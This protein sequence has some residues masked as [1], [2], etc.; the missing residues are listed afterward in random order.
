MTESSDNTLDRL[1]EILK[2]IS[3]D[4][5]LQFLNIDPEDITPDEIRFDRSGRLR[6]WSRL[7]KVVCS[8]D[9]LRSHQH[10]LAFV[11]LLGHFSAG[12]STMINAIVG[13]PGQREAYPNPT[14][15]TITLICH[16]RNIADLR[17]NPFTSI[18]GVTIE[19]G[20]SIELLEN[21]V[22]VDTPGL[23]NLAAEHDMAERFLHLCHVIVVTIDGQVP[24]ADTAGNLSLLDKIINK[25]GDVPKIF[26]VTKSVQF[27]SDRKG[28]FATHWN[29][30][31]ADNF[32]AGVTS[33]LTSDARFSRAGTSIDDIPVIFVDSIDGYNIG[34]LIEKFVPIT[35]DAS[36]RPRTYDAQ[37][38]Y[39]VQIALEAIK[40]FNAYLQDRLA[41][42][43]SL[44]SQ[45][46]TKADEARNM[47][48]RRQDAVLSAIVTATTKIDT[49]QQADDITQ[50]LLPVPEPT[51]VL[52]RDRFGE[53][54]AAINGIENHLRDV[55]RETTNSLR[56]ESERSTGGQFRLFF[57]SKKEY[58][59]EE[60]C[61]NAMDV[62]S[63][64]RSYD[65]HNLLIA[66]ASY[67]EKAHDDIVWDI[68][69]RWSNRSLERSAK[70][71]TTAFTEAFQALAGGLGTFISSYNVAAR[72]FVAY[73]TQP[74]SKKLMAEYGVVL[75]DDDDESL[76]LEAAELANSDFAAFGTADKV[77]KDVRT[78]LARIVDD[79]VRELA[80]SNIGDISQRL[81][82]PSFEHTD[83]HQFYDNHDKRFRH[84]ANQ[85]LSE[86]QANIEASKTQMAEA[87]A[88]CKDT[89]KDIWLGWFEFTVKM[90]V[91]WVVLYATI[92]IVKRS[93]FQLY[94]W[95]ADF[96][97]TSWEVLLLSMVGA[98]IVELL[99]FGARRN[100]DFVSPSTFS[101]GLRAIYDFAKGKKRIKTAFD[102]YLDS[103]SGRLRQRLKEKSLE[104][105]AQT[106][107]ILGSKIDAAVSEAGV[108]DLKDVLQKYRD[109]R[110]STYQRSRQLFMNSTN[111]LRTELSTVSE[112]KSTESVDRV[113]ER[114][115]DTQIAVTTFS[116]EMQTFEKEL[117]PVSGS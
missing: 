71:I 30:T 109:E 116:E 75:F 38:K 70:V 103:A 1:A 29:Q 85:F 2:S 26:A 105:S 104:I 10:G 46:R 86:V 52:L 43:S 45:A 91:I 97:E 28:D 113:L 72:A 23:G 106:H 19:A 87:R 95:L 74:T 41:N 53:F 6:A 80:D 51:E 88:V 40:V 20:P 99:K 44:H 112:T 13:D 102:E 90:G 79:E 4:Q 110:V 9:D 21:I 32:W 42:L 81:G 50:R 92:A 82:V 62:L 8:I 24:L 94:D 54:H 14:D 61:R 5:H 64:L 63:N 15:K 35:Q 34:A 25:L 60:L 108:A 107:R 114:I 73:L 84:E 66:I 57:C 59:K 27:L 16:P 69:S 111:T 78:E 77:S 68:E 47:L 83:L 98:L 55:E 117:A 115:S 11:G 58:P 33:R 100:N 31:A 101:F 7:E 56:K 89:V 36:Q 96:A 48:A 65:E 76:A 3:E 12:K 39:V 22:L 17:E 49:L 93:D 67:F 18:D 37:V